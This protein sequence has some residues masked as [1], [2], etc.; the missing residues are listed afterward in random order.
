MSKEPKI[1]IDKRD[2]MNNK[3]SLYI[4]I[5]W[6]LQSVFCGYNDRDVWSVKDFIIKKISKPVS[7]FV[8]YQTNCGRGLP[9]EFSKDPAAWLEILRK[10]QFSFE[11]ISKEFSGDIEYSDMMIGMTPEEHVKHS[12]RIQE[13]FELFG[14]Y[15]LDL[16]D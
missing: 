7:D 3:R 13:G 2:Y 16:R 9:A 6:F 12:E 4:R 14:K 5:K 15:L 8:E 11:N 10:I 1:L